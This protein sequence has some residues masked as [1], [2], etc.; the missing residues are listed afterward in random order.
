MLPHL[1]IFGALA[2]LVYFSG[3]VRYIPNS[4]VGVV[5]KMWAGAGSIKSGFIA[6]NGEAGYQPH[7]L[8]G[9][10]H[11]FTPFQYRVRSVPLV[12][13]T[14]GQIG[15]VFARDG[16]PL[17]PGQTLASNGT[18]TSF[19]D[20]RTFLENGGQK[21]PQRKI[22]RE[23]TYALNLAQFVVL[24]ADS[25]FALELDSS[26]E[27]LFKNMSKTL[28]ERNGFYP[29]VITD[30][31]DE[32]G[33]VTVHDG[34]A[35]PQGEIIAPAVGTTV[36][37]AEF[38]N[39]F[40]DPDVF[41]KYGNRGRQYQVLVDGTYYINRLF[42]TIE[43]ISK[44]VVPVGAV[45]V[46]V[47]YTGKQ[48]ADRSE[49][50]YRHGE[51]VDTGFRG[52]WAEPLLPG[53]YAFN[54]YA[55]KVMVVP[56]TN[57]ILKWSSEVT[58]EHKFDQNLSE[59]TL[60]TKDAFEPTLPLSVVVHIDYKK[61]SRVIQR[62]GDIKRLVEQTLDPMVS[63][64]FKNV[65]QTRTLIELLQQRSD[66]QEKSADE[67]RKKFADYSLELQEVLIGTP[68]SVE[69]NGQIEEI[70][71]QLRDRQIAV[72]QVATYQLKEAA[73]VQERSLREAEAVALQQGD[74]TRSLLSVQVRENEGR[75]EVA[76]ATE[77]AK[78][79]TIEAGAEAARLKATGEGEASR[80]RQVGEAEAD[81]TRNK[82]EAFGGPQYQ[83]AQ[84]VFERF[85][86]AIK[87]GN[88]PIVPQIQMSGSEGK[89][90]TLVDAM[91]AMLLKDGLPKMASSQ[92]SA[93]LSLEK[94]EN[95]SE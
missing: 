47:S 87:E 61:A 88:V 31:S 23:G 74:I 91:L 18:A 43:R 81:A 39:N 57:F 37:E 44:T 46:V 48:G 93:P 4:R 13:I 19:E 35:L 69:G 7:I 17:L 63:A 94:P 10:F 95:K 79:I 84:Q 50:D 14:Q 6:L 45:G 51:L 38:H 52:V 27:D 22:L 25:L 83:L 29:V 92:E 67:M 9:G 70:L 86:D 40:Q 58:S 12:T 76:F 33:V 24:T 21:G 42:A 30:A 85:A 75:A 71:R 8:R 28:H 68:R 80:I 64:Y 36:G 2:A 72:E 1:V 3:V 26:E 20:V 55:G 54:T 5:E 32:I 90:G 56:T 49:E 15:Y 82:V 89:S 62:F 65:G 66:I 34:P 60:I 78:R 53:K 77:T 41:V 59:V 11:F 16:Q 73:A